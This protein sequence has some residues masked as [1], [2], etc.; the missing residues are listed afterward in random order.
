MSVIFKVI[1][2]WLPTLALSM[3]VCPKISKTWNLLKKNSPHISID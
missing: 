1:L 3:C 2:K